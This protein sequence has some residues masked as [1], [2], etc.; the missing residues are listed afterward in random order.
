MEETD[1]CSSSR[2]NSTLGIRTRLQKPKP[3]KTATA[4]YLNNQSKSPKSANGGNAIQANNTFIQGSSAA[5]Q[6]LPEGKLK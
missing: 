5:F 6:N 3:L 1:F 4:S 2:P